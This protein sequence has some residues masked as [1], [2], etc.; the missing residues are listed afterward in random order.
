MSAMLILLPLGAALA[1]WLA[2][3]DRLGD[4]IALPH[5]DAA[6]ISASVNAAMQA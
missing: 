3:L 4:R 2:P 1:I 5:A 6:R